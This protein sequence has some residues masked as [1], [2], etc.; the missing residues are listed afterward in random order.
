[1]GSFEHPISQTQLLNSSNRSTCSK[2]TVRSLRV[3]PVA[4]TTV[5]PASPRRLQLIHDDSSTD[6]ASLASSFRGV[7][8]YSRLVFS[9]AGHDLGEVQKRQSVSPVEQAHSDSHARPRV[10]ERPTARCDEAAGC[11]V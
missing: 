5:G 7:L 3:I 11:P 9:R 4:M 1:M 2:L 6:R 8:T 10:H